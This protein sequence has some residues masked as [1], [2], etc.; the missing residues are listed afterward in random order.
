[1]PGP[2]L[3][4]G[5]VRLDC[6]RFQLRRG[7]RVLKLERK[8][9]ELLVLLATREGEVVLRSEIAGHLWSSGVFVDT[10][11]GIN[12]AIRKVR[13]ALRDDPDHPRFVQTVTGRG[14]RF[15][16]PVAT[17]QP[18]SALGS[19][20]PA[21]QTEIPSPE[22]SGAFAAAAHPPIARSRLWLILGSLAALLLIVITI[23]LRLRE[24]T[25][26]AAI[27]L[28]QSLA[29]LPL[30]NLSGDPAQ[31][32]FAAGMT[33]ELTT[34]LA[35]D[36]TLRVISR[37]SAM[38]YKDAHRPLREIAGSLGVDGIVEGSIAR[39]DGKV[40]MTLQLIHAPSDTHI[41][42]DSYDRN[43]N[44]VAALSAEAAQAI[45]KR[46]NASITVPKPV[47]YVN[48]Q[49]HDAYLRG[50]YLLYTNG[51]ES[52]SY[53]KKATELQPDYALGWAGLTLYYGSGAGSTLDPTKVLAPMEAA[54][55]RAVDL[56][57][58]L[59]EAHLARGWALFNAK[60]DWAAGDRELLR[61]IELN[62][63]Y[64]EAI[65]RRAEF[66]AALNRNQEAIAAQKTAT[67]IDPFSRPRAMALLYVW[68][69][70]YDAAITDIQ[71][72]L[73]TRPDDVG[74]L[75]TL[76][77]AYRCKGMKKEAV[78]TLER[79][80][81]VSGGNSAW[82]AWKNS[83]EDVRRA[84]ER[85]GYNAV[86]QM[87]ITSLEGMAPKQYV[88]PVDLALLYAQLGKRKE[89]LALLEAGLRERNP[90]L[91]WIQCDPAYDFLHNDERYR[92]LIKKIG[93]PPGW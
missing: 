54:A 31:D 4:F 81:N 84:W 45:A 85:G 1:V 5:D 43:N 19:A 86:L 25:T 13:Q 17:I 59:P 82:Y 64:S 14:Y 47:R 63:Q 90:G 75:Y 15:V 77:V 74:L 24:H 41:W 37:T 50:M 92:T 22:L 55:R 48:P 91:L 33:D 66:L 36:S 52:G 72:R 87:Q 57:D 8:P 80:L 60:W 51:D 7:A 23:T 38:Q 76:H 16:G 6:D 73:Q 34:M 69:R 62:P 3:E 71:Q 26:H 58:S 2:I 18:M 56:D 46:L 40:H 30:N 79:Y 12:T 21:S 65:H 10:E 11:H 35:K 49:A 67:E 20:P 27:P 28:I 29:V 32:Y 9:M 42:A 61:A 39:A 89:T 70:Q 68:A 53:F 78:R 93:L 88:S 44:E 83:S